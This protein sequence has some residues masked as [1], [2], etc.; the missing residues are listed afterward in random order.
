MPPSLARALHAVI[1]N[2]GHEAWSLREKFDA[3]I[4]DVDLY[5]RLGKE[6]DWVVISKD[7]SQAKRPPERAAILRHGVVAI[8]LSPSVE[9]QPP[10]QQAATILWHWDAIVLQ[11]KSQANGLFLLPVNKGAKFRSL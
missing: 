9:K 1:V 10:H 2:T 5:E 6:R 11:R 3:K 7:V 4:S 8:F